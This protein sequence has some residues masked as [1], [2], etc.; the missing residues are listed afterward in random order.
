MLHQILSLLAPRDL[1]A[2]VLVC[3]VWREVGEAP[4]LWSW[5]DLR[6][7]RENQPNMLKFLERRKMKWVRQMRVEDITDE[8]L[9]TVIRL[10]WVTHPHPHLVRVIHLKNWAFGKVDRSLLARV[11]SGVRLEYH[12]NWIGME[13]T[14][15]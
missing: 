9:H 3:R 2:A 12:S 14:G 8:V 15:R 5:V 4:G 11:R 1:Q 7:T 13:W 10:K 6:V